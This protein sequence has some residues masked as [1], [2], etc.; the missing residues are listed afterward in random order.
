MDEK[1]AKI[2][3]LERIIAELRAEIAELKRRLGLNSRNSGKPPGSDGLAKKP[4]W[5]PKSLRETGKNPSGGRKGS[6]GSRSQSRE[7][8]QSRSSAG[9]RPSRSGGQKSSGRC[10]SSQSIGRC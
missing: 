2:E 10:G 3:A 1:D 6:T 7:R 8:S 4:A 5:Q 9:G